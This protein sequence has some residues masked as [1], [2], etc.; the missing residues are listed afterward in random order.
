M[1]RGMSG[2]Q[3]G[4]EP[5]GIEMKIPIQSGN[6]SKRE[7]IEASIQFIR[8]DEGLSLNGLEVTAVLGGYHTM[9]G[10]ALNVNGEQIEFEFSILVWGD[11]DSD[12]QMDTG[13]VPVDGDQERLGNPTDTNPQ[14]LILDNIEG[15]IFGAAALLILVLLGVMFQLSRKKNK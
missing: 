15:V 9:S 7:T 11:Q 13:I 10:Y 14:G 2:I 12:G 6:V 1:A 3:M 8:L 4:K 5:H